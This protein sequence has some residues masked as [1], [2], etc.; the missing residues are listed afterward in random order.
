[1]KGLKHPNIIDFAS[2]EIQ[3]EKVLIF[4]EHAEN[5][6]LT[7][8]MRANPTITEEQVLIWA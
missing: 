8:V 1:M 5:G 3:K 2:F 4:M 6:S 7:D